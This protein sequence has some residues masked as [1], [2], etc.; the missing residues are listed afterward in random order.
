MS[1]LY[2]VTAERDTADAFL[3]ACST[4]LAALGDEEQALL[5]P[6]AQ[7][8]AISE[9]FVSMDW[10]KLGPDDVSVLNWS[11][12]LVWL[13]RSDV[14]GRKPGAVEVLDTAYEGPRLRRSE[15]E[16]LLSASLQYS[17]GRSGLEGASERE[18]KVRHQQA[19]EFWEMLDVHGMASLGADLPAVG[20]ALARGELVRFDATALL[21]A[22]AFNVTAASLAAAEGQQARRIAVLSEMP[23]LPRSLDFFAKEMAE[24]RLP[25][26]FIK[27][28]ASHLPGFVNVRRLPRF[29]EQLPDVPAALHLTDD[30][31]HA[32]SILWLGPMS[33]GA[34]HPLSGEGP[35]YDA[36][37]NVYV[38][39]AGEADVLLLPPAYTDLF[40]WKDN[41]FVFPRS[42][43]EMRAWV[44]SSD[45][46]ARVPFVL[47]HL[48]PGDG[49]TLPSRAYHL[50]MAQG[51]ERV[52]LNYFFHPRWRCMQYNS[53]DLASR[54]KATRLAMNKLA[55]L[56]SQRVWREKGKAVFT[57]TGRFE[58]I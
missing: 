19:L 25:L 39:L 42:I 35:H 30:V 22:A 40:D 52:A 9:D 34:W 54:T 23:Y 20:Q 2:E 16:E 58:L 51:T 48:R 33:S 50:F 38:Q 15:L 1:P 57:D 18:F 41:R 12:G 31:L 11:N 37:A 45:L 26:G 28:E 29:A 55:L 8:G 32:V 49:L 4:E 24:T 5:E 44:R 10:G 36:Q 27:Q 43:E 7:A 6:F 17:L 14:A 3:R 53:T 47:A 13:N 21:P 46:P 56:A